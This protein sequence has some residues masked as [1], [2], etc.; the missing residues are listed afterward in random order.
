MDIG[1]ALDLTV[2]QLAGPAHLHCCL[3]SALAESANAPTNIVEDKE[4]V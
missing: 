2:L 3:N 1:S 4:T